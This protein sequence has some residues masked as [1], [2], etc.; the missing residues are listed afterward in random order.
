[1]RHLLLALLFLLPLSVGGLALQEPPPEQR[2][3]CTPSH[4]HNRC[5]CL[6]MGGWKQCKDGKRETE[7]Q[8]CK[9]YCAKDNCRCCTTI[10]R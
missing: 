10:Q 9:S 3:Y 4:L 6:K 7:V 1:M 8:T 5:E 2:G